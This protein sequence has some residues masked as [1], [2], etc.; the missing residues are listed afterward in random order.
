[1]MRKSELERLIVLLGM[2]YEVA[3]SALAADISKVRAHVFD[4][5]E[6]KE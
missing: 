3:D 5:L 1:M 6:A 4:K 2:F